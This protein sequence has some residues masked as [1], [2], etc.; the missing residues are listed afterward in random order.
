MGLRK[1]KEQGQAFVEYLL[2][3]II[4]LVLGFG[5][6][7]QFNSAFRQ[8]LAGEGGL[9]GKS[10][11]LECLVRSGQLPFA[12]NLPADQEKCSLTPMEDFHKMKPKISGGLSGGGGSGLSGSSNSGSGNGSNSSANQGGSPASDGKPS[13][14]TVPASAADSGGG[15][16][17]GLSKDPNQSGAGTRAGNK[18][19][20]ESYTGSDKVSSANGGGGD[21]GQ[22]SSDSLRP[23]FFADQK[24]GSGGTVK[25]A[26][27]KAIPASERD[28]KSKDLIDAEAKQKR[29]LSMQDD[30]PFT[31]G[32][33]LRWIAIVLIIFFIL[34]FVGTQLIAISRGQKR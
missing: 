33:S 18:S 8:Y 20:N 26:S 13:G 7:Y 19:T 9:F 10:G 14:R 24:L 11:Y 4:V 25:S 15:A 12:T 27:G 34:F 1:N 16:F 31:F 5:L 29:K 22:D 2:L 6:F 3:L 32:A 21:G 23:R 30:E 28:L 17:K